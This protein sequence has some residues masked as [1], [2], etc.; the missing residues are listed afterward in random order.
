MVPHLFHACICEGATELT[1]VAGYPI[2]PENREL[3]NATLFAVDVWEP[4][5]MSLGAYLRDHRISVESVGEQGLVYRTHLACKTFQE[6]T[7]R[8]LM[9]FHLSNAL[10]NIRGEGST[11][12]VTDLVVSDYGDAK[13][14]RGAR[15]LSCNQNQVKALFEDFYDDMLEDERVPRLGANAVVLMD[16]CLDGPGLPTGLKVVDI[17]FGR[18]YPRGMKP[19]T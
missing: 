15:P 16:A 14:A 19:N 12:V 2:P 8:N 13:L 3:F 17:F 6:T 5:A 7:G 1:E 10:V 9:D 11:A 18:K 4:F